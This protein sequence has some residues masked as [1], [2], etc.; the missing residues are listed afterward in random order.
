MKFG[1]LIPN[2]SEPWLSYSQMN[3]MQKINA[4]SNAVG[5]MIKF[6]ENPTQQAN[7]MFIALTE[8]KHHSGIY[9][10]PFWFAKYK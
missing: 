2:D 8:F 4:K 1:A 6:N 10:T 3:I 7:C 9:S 5:A